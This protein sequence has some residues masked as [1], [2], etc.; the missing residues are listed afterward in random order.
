M[1]RT[2]ILV[3]NLLFY[4]ALFSQD[5]PVDSIPEL[6]YRK[7]VSSDIFKQVEVQLMVHPEYKKIRVVPAEYKSV[8]EKVLIKPAHNSKMASDTTRW[9][10]DTI[11]YN[12]QEPS[13][14]IT[15]TSAV[16]SLGAET[17]EVKPATA[18]WDM[19]DTPAADCG[20]SDP[21]DCRYWS[22][23]GV[24]AEYTSVSVRRLVSDASVK[25][26][27]NEPIRRFYLR[28][29]PL[30]EIPISIIDRPAEYITIST[31][32]VSKPSIIEEE[33]IPAIYKTI[34][35]E[36][37]EKKGGQI[38][39]VEVDCEELNAELEFFG[40]YK[41]FYDETQP[42]D[43]TEIQFGD[44]NNCSN[45]EDFLRHNIP[46]YQYRSTD[47]ILYFYKSVDK[48]NTLFKNFH[49][50]EVFSVNHSKDKK[51]EMD[52]KYFKTPSRTLSNPART[53]RHTENFER[54]RILLKNCI[55]GE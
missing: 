2:I 13:S 20:S 12:F 21:N 44:S 28:M 11:Y 31:Q 19:S 33:V 49:L 23:K 51:I 39:L 15:I 25:I 18:R 10:I 40:K 3:I 32:I 42:Y 14:W 8:T 6:C 54:T 47:K 7:V 22:Y 53:D 30:T 38:E 1:K 16:F 36:V 55:H 43:Q 17:I 35:K 34:S 52:V 5:L 48:I 29:T 9:K 45:Y 37:L 4:I 26:I 50:M 46:G 27:K 41:D 24:P